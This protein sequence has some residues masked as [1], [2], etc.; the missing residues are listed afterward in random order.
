MV[1][2]QCV[3]GDEHEVAVVEGLCG[4]GGTLT[5]Q[6]TDEVTQRGI[7]RQWKKMMSQREEAPGRQ[8]ARR[9][10]QQAR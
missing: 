5:G 3:E 1:G 10:I 9:E 8:R 4:R 6:M 7:W 2:A